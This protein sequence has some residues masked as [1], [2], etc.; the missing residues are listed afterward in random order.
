MALRTAGSKVH[1]FF[2]RR[3]KNMFIEL[4][5]DGV[6]NDLN[7]NVIKLAEK[8]FKM[9]LDAENMDTYDYL[10]YPEN[11]RNYIFNLFTKPELMTNPDFLFDDAVD[12]LKWLDKEDKFTVQLRTLVSTK[13]VQASRTIFLEELFEENNIKNISINV[14]TS[15]PPIECD[16]LIEDNPKAIMKK[17]DG[18]VIMMEHSYNSYI[19]ELNKENIVTIKNLTELKEVLNN[20]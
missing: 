8:E 17:E 10:V 3:E 2:D 6:L 15:K 14:V 13:D 7:G 11:I 18:L 1:V 16:I 9:N 19:K 4:D 12:F 20:L 5:F